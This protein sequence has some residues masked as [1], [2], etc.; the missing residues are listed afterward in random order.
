MMKDIAWKNRPKIKVK[1]AGIDK[2]L[3]A[4]SVL[5]LIVLWV[6]VL[7]A[8]SGLPNEIPTHFNHL[9]VADR[10]GSKVHILFLPAIATA[11]GVSLTILSNYPHTFNYP[12]RIT[13]ENMAYQYTNSL[14]MLRM[15]KIAVIFIF[16]LLAWTT[17]GY[18]TGAIQVI[19]KW[20]LPILMTTIFLPILIYLAL[21]FKRK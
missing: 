12:V 6:L 15:L 18:N 7:R 2:L 13:A 17:I 4:V 9:G 5:L 19:G 16:T 14:R 20:F 21:A 3:E 8:Y 11:L 1:L 10:Y